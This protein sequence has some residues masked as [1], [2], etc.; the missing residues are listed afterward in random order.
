M[1]QFYTKP[2]KTTGRGKRWSEIDR[3]KFEKDV[4]RCK[5]AWYKNW[6]IAEY[7][8]VSN[9]TI[10]WI[11]SKHWKENKIFYKKEKLELLLENVKELDEMILDLRNDLSDLT[12]K[13]RSLKLKY[14]EK[15]EK[16]LDSRAK[17]LWFSNNTILL[18]DSEDPIDDILK[19]LSND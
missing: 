16:L 17:L 1:G 13:E 14:I 18:K 6:E 4:S 19:K 10:D 11:T 3:I 7:F 9:P 12:K 2:R 8:N 5:Y 15:I